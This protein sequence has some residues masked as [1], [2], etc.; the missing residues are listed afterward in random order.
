MSQLS[1]E[2]SSVS[3]AKKAFS[4]RCCFPVFVNKPSY[5]NNQTPLSQTNNP[6]NLTTHISHTHSATAKW[7]SCSVASCQPNKEVSGTGARCLQTY[8]GHQRPRWQGKHREGGRRTPPNTKLHAYDFCL[9][10]SL[11][12]SLHLFPSLQMQFSPSLS[13][14]LSLSL[15]M[16]TVSVMIYP[17]S[18]SD[19]Y[20]HAFPLFQWVLLSN[21]TFVVLDMHQK[22]G[23]IFM[24]Q[25]SNES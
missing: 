2:H 12:R 20:L 14:S 22:L 10:L 25:G 9:S 15:P 13:L 19:V 5:N 7:A 23:S 24:N 3:L 16:F 11:P 21:Q 1:H 8:P 6:S 4:S 17:T 18:L